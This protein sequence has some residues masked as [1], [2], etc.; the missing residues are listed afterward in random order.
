MTRDRLNA[1]VLV[2]LAIPMVG[3]HLALKKRVK[4]EEVVGMVA[5]ANRPAIWQGR[6][7][8]E[9]EL[10]T[11]EGETFRLS[12]HVGKEVVVLNFFAT[13][14]GPCREE[15]PELARFAGQYQ[16]RPLRLLAVD[17][18]EK[19]AVVRS[20]VART[21]VPLAVAID[22]SGGVARQYGVDSYPTTVVVGADGAIVLHQSG[23]ISNADVTL[24]PA[25]RQALLRVERRQGIDRETYL[26]RAR[27][28]AIVAPDAPPVLTGRAL[29]ISQRMDCPCGCVDKV[30]KCQC[31]TAKAIRSRL[32]RESLE[33]R[34]DEQ[35]VKDLD[36][37]FCMRG[38]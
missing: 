22:D 15:M 3:F 12:D 28:S 25:V 34:T 27:G 31:K 2:A 1:V 11:L 5:T 24:A 33:G 35:I 8:A 38:M 18:E 21:N 36:R 7:A 30:A 29:E 37:E 19:E 20:F 13:W 32:A 6:V 14:C 4:P 9:F 17:V 10:K 26:A 23:A 16:G